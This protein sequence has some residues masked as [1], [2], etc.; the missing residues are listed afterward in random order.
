MNF[1]DFQNTNG[2]GDP[3][4]FGTPDVP[5][6]LFIDNSDPFA[7]PA[8]ITPPAPS[9][10]I[11]LIYEFLEQN[12]E[13]SGHRDAI[14]SGDT[15]YM[16]DNIQ[17]LKMSLK[18]KIERVTTFYED[19][20]SEV[21]LH[22]ETHGRTGSVDTVEKLR[23]EKEKCAAHMNKLVEIR[24]GIDKE[25][26][27]CQSIIQSYRRGFVRGLAYVAISQFGR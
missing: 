22:I 11:D 12:L 27:P 13:S 17:Q 21:D 1:P 15:A 2:Q 16:N 24:E 4:T 3:Q 8:T 14:T 26:G 19:R 6:N 9:K 23:T 10:G 7:V 5:E 20:L 18:V 25:L